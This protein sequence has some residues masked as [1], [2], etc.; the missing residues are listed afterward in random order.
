MSELQAIA[1]RFEI[2]RFLNDHQRVQN[3][4]L[5]FARRRA[6]VRIPSAPL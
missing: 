3:H 5:A 1:D 6:W 2:S 4:E